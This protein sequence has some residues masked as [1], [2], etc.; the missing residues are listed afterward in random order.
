MNKCGLRIC[1]IDRHF[2]L[3]FLALTCSLPL[4]TQKVVFPAPG[5]N[6]GVWR[7][8]HDPHVRDWANRYNTQCF[9]PDGRFLCYTHYPNGKNDTATVRIFDLHKDEAR[10]VGPGFNPRWAKQNNWLIYSTYNPAKAKGAN[11][12]VENMFHDADTGTTKVLAP[13]L[14]AEVLGETDADDRWIFGLQRNRNTDPQYRTVRI[15]L[16]DGKMEFL[17]EVSGIHLLPNP[18]HPL[19]FTRQASN[20]NPLAATRAFYDLD[21]SNRR[22]GVPTLQKCHMSWLGNGEYFLLGNGL[23]RGRKWNEPFPSS[24]H[25][26]AW[27]WMGD[28]SP[29]GA[30]GRWACGDSVVADL[31]SGD[32]W[33]TIE[34]FSQLCL[35]ATVVD[36]SEIYD[37]DPKGSPDGTKIGFV[38]NYPLDTGPVTHITDV[39]RDSL[40]VA[41]TEGFPG[42]GEIVVKREVIRYENKT[43]TLFTGLLRKVYNTEGANLRQ[44]QIV[45]SFQARCLTDKQ[46]NSLKE[47][48]TGLAKAINDPASPLMRQR[49]TDI[50]LVVVRRPDR[51]YFRVTGDSIEL[52]PGEN[53]RETFG[54]HLL[55]GDERI[56]K[57]TLAPGASFTL[58]QSGVWRAIA[59]ENSGL[60]SEPSL[61]IKLPAGK[62]AIL[63]NKPSDFAWTSTRERD[64]V[65]ETIHLHDGVIRRE[66]LVDGVLTRRH[67]LNATGKAT[68]RINYKNGLIAT[69]EYYRPDDHLVSRE[70]F[71]KYGPVAEHIRF[72]AESNGGAGDIPRET[73]HY[74]RGMPIRHMKHDTGRQYFKRG[75]R[76]GYLDNKGKFIDTP[77]E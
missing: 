64:G 38:S 46:F 19:F 74:D 24:V 5:N 26:L 29:C 9:S 67:D 7:L 32:G 41:S 40:K 44:N 22:I 52:I 15:S 56:T 21:G 65:L 42:Q 48:H 12:G 58:E 76:W 55:L 28:V 50:H 20:T 71:D 49:M 17:P 59:V 75:N 62:L 13:H 8:T 60:E 54:Y 16:P 35:P 36:G 6:F 47:P 3:I 27:E 69:R 2:Y 63:N 57:S 30:S 61:P 53:H 25:I 14:G 45:T 34:P 37:A 77:R 72:L 11:R 31:R 73:W 51:P 43:P 1:Y 39:R 18:R 10:V 68:R 4:Y 66:W 33:K 23:F 70:T